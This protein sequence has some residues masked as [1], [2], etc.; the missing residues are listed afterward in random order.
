MDEILGIEKFSS[1]FLKH[2]NLTKTPCTWDRDYFTL[3]QD[4]YNYLDHQ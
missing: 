4:R 3:F 1:Q 2:T